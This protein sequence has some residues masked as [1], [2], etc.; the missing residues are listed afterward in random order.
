MQSHSRHL[1]N[2]C[3]QLSAKNTHKSLLAFENLHTEIMFV[4]YQWSFA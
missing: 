1:T 3:P 2:T 4:I